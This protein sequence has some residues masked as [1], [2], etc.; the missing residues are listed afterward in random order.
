MGNTFL[1][2]LNAGKNF[3]ATNVAGSGKPNT[4]DIN[5]HGISEEAERAY[6][7]AGGSE[8]SI[9]DWRKNFAANASPQTVRL[10]LQK[11]TEMLGSKMN[12][13]ERQVNNALG[14]HG[15][16]YQGIAPETQQ[17]L[18]VLNDP[19]LSDSD[20]LQKIAT[21]KTGM[22]EEANKRRRKAAADAKIAAARPPAPAPGVPR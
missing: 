21:L 22:D 19:D 1:P 7:N 5:V 17:L 2:S 18:N 13:N 4:F 10:G 14:G 6:R 8:S 12:E 9:Q 3:L 20:A 15:T 11:L 16:P